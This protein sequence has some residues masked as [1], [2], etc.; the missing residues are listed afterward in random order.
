V[1]FHCEDLRDFGVVLVPPSSR[2]YE[3][4]FVEIQRRVD[5]SL[6]K[7]ETSAI[8]VNRSE[9]SIAAIDAVWR[10]EDVAG[11]EFQGA[12]LTTGDLL[13]MPFSAPPEALKAMVY[14]MAILPGSRRYLG[15]NGLAGDNADVRG[16]EPDEVWR[17]GWIFGS[18]GGGCTPALPIK[19][20]MLIL[21]G[22]FFLDGE[23]AGPNRNRL[24]E[25]VTK[26]AKSILD[27]AKIARSGKDRGLAAAEILR[28]IE[29]LT[30]PPLEPPPAPGTAMQRRACDI[31]QRRHLMGDER[32][33]EWLASRAQAPIP[34]FRRLSLTR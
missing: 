30:G 6:E 18:G 9:K 16:P 34:N 28:E 24:W 21:D 22:V 15:E 33:V 23:F 1:T 25:K 31:K 11:R 17:R 13:L 20:V 2:D 19:S 10:Y 12:R 26:E 3:P 5:H 29:E 4:L 32:T 8:L 14:R 7:R 27:V